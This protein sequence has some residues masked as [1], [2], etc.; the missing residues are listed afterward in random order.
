MTDSNS[1]IP[2]KINSLIQEIET[3]FQAIKAAKESELNPK[4]DLA[5]TSTK[6]LQVKIQGKVDDPKLNSAIAKMTDV[7]VIDKTIVKDEIETLKQENEALAS[8]LPGK[9]QQLNLPE[10]DLL[11]LTTAIQNWLNEINKILEDLRSLS[12]F[13]QTTDSILLNIKEKFTQ[14][15]QIFES[16]GTLENLLYEIKAEMKKVIGEPNLTDF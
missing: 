11:E 8:A 1:P 14:L 9:L 4:L 3:K 6:N 5:K 12:E 16:E 13:N 7:L 15:S 10:P 2:Q